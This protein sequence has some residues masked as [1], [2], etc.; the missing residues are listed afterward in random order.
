MKLVQLMT[1][2]HGR[3][4]TS[5]IDFAVILGMSFDVSCSILGTKGKGPMRE[6]L[7]EGREKIQ[8][9]ESFMG[10]LYNPY[11]KGS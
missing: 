5:R 6:K 11:M 7:V 4:K 3:Q 2:Q 9:K 1:S 10:T 8:D